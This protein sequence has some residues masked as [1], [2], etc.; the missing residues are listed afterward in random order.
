[1]HPYRVTAIW[2]SW[3]MIMSSYVSTILEIWAT[4]TLTMVLW[5]FWF[6]FNT[7][8][9]CVSWFLTEL[10]QFYLIW[11]TWFHT[12]WTLWSS[13]LMAHIPKAI[14]NWHVQHWFSHCR[15]N[16]ASFKC[17]NYFLTRGRNRPSNKSVWLPD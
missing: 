13:D 7:L 5:Q 17:K 2:S 15:C 12:V 4:M 11:T 3:K 14:R 16:L 10:L 8:S 9:V 1:M 6:T